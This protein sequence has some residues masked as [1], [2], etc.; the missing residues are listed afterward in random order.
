MGRQAHRVIRGVERFQFCYLSCRASDIFLQFLWKRQHP[1]S[2]C[3][4]TWLSLYL[5]A[6]SGT[7]RRALLPVLLPLLLQSLSSLT[8]EE[9][10]TTTKHVEQSPSFRYWPEYPPR[11]VALGDSCAR[12]GDVA[13]ACWCWKRGID[14]WLVK[15]N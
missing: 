13:R 5:S 11:N 2:P 6:T 12:V 1:A 9:K 8:L 10:H 4:R 7:A 15:E 3:S 14:S